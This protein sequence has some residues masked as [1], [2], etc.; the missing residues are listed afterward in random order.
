[1]DVKLELALSTVTNP[2]GSLWAGTIWLCWGPDGC[3]VFRIGGW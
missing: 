2:M 3:P 1:M